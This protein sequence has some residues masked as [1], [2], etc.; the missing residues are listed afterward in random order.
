[1]DGIYDELRLCH[2]RQFGSH[3][4]PGCFHQSKD[5]RERMGK[6]V[7]GYSKQGKPV[8]TEDLDVAGAMT[9]WMVKA[10]N[11]TSCRQ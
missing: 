5:M 6:I 11:P 9:S 2:Y 4:H 8:T 3:G 1:M 10:I 7:V